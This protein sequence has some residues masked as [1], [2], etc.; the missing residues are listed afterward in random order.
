MQI[1]IMLEGQMGLNWPRW[2]RILQIAEDGGYQHVFRSDHYVNPQPPDMDSLELWTSLTYAASHTKRIEFGPMVAPVT[3]RHP[4]MA[5]RIAA[6]I[7]DLSGGRCV[8]GM[9]AGW[10]E[11]EHRD[12]GIP[13]YDFKTRFEMLED[14]LEITTRLYNSAEPVSYEGKHFSL[15]NAVLLPRPQRPG[16]PPILI[17]GSGPNKS[18]PLTAKY[19]AE[20]NA[21]FGPIEKFRKN[22]ALLDQ[23]IAEAGRKPGDIKRSIPTQTVFGKDDADLRAKLQERGVS[24][25]DELWAR[26]ITAGTASE[27]VDRLRMWQEAGV[28]RL[29]LQWLDLDDIASLELIARDV[30]PHFHKT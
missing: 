9:G 17:G 1:G 30:L 10:N 6:Q 14:A 25:T 13:F 8:M 4:V 7:D 3:F 15:N 28:E 11:R 24:S 22:N 12:F 16:G 26:G 29:L 23:R 19:A 2:Q 18:L 20:W 21:G 5:A 27:L